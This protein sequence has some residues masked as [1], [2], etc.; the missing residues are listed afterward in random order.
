[1]GIFKRDISLFAPAF[2]LFAGACNGFSPGYI[3]A[4][5]FADPDNIRMHSTCFVEP[6]TVILF[7]SYTIFVSG[8]RQNR[9][10]R[11]L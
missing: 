6:E 1:M 7:K 11:M 4:A 8:L 9:I 5:S 2:F 10:M 3:E